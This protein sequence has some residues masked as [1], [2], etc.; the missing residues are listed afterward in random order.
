MSDNRNGIFGFLMDLSNRQTSVTQLFSPALL[1]SIG[2]HL[3]LTSSI[4]LCFDEDNNFLSWTDKNGVRS[5][6]DSHP[7]VGF[8][9]ND[10][11]EHVVFYTSFR[12]KL[13]Y[14][15]SMPKIYL[16]SEIISPVDYDNSAYVRFLEEQ[17][18]MH[19]SVSLAFGIYGYIQLL[20]FK[21]REEGDFTREEIMELEN[22]YIAIAGTYINFKKHEQA[23]IMSDMK[24]KVISSNENAYFITDGFQHILMC[25]EPASAYLKE[26]FDA[27]DGK[28]IDPQEEQTWLPFVFRNYDPKKE[29]SSV[30]N[31]RNYHFSIYEHQQT[32]NHGIIERYYLIT[33]R[34]NSST[35][36]GGALP[37]KKVDEDETIS[38]L[39]AS[40]KRIA[41]LLKQGMT[42]RE[43][44]EEL[45]ISYHTVKKHVENIY[46]KLGI[47]NR[48]Q[49]YDLMQ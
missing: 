8:A 3:G 47:K 11:V 36:V 40:E 20:F 21:T 30:C 32:Y 48:Y 24:D 34:E 14:F 37:V 9:Q 44:A 1:E 46:A 19:Y 26:L 17:F 13:T 23:Q 15:N 22:L 2:R 43:I 49:L 41:E 16:S 12:E 10:V 25:N 27:G 33:I 38:V 5:R 6:C 18:G 42:Y 39:T 45:F 31:I 29:E 4:V 7:Y 35:S 28:D